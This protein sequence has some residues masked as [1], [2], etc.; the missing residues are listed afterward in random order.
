MAS[1]SFRLLRAARCPS[2]WLLMLVLVLPA[3]VSAQSLAELA[4]GVVL[5]ANDNCPDILGTHAC[6]TL[7]GWNI[8]AAVPIVPPLAVVAEAGRFSGTLNESGIGHGVSLMAG[9]RVMWRHERTW[10][11]FA[12]ALFGVVRATGSGDDLVLLGDCTELREPLC[13]LTQMVVTSSTTDFAV[14][15]GGGIDFVPG[16]GRVAVRLAGDFRRVHQNPNYET[17]AP[18]YVTSRGTERHKAFAL[19]DIEELSVRL[20][21]GIV[22]RL[23]HA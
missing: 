11:P 10:R 23:S 4:G 1:N 19:Y 22:W 7:P 21:V 18:P 2:L 16:A 3:S 17:S 12:Q 9:P 13:H 14:Q 20:W 6:N 15:P 8:D 5:H